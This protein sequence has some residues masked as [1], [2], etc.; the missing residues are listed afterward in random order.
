MNR[1]DFAATV[2]AYVGTP[3]VH[4][5]R[6]PGPKGGMDCPAPIILAAREHGIVAP[7]FDVTGYGRIP[8]GVGLKGFCDAHLIPLDREPDVG[9]VLLCAWGPAQPPH[10]LGVLVDAT[11]G[12][13]YWVHAEGLAHKRVMRSRLVFGSRAMRLVQAYQVPGVE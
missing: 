9:D 6:V 3:F 4:Q 12:R 2:L 10:H 8:D 13:M 5:G 11:P 1:H 7:D